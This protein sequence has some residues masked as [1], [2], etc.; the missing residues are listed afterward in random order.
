M[1]K[2]GRT[3]SCSK[4]RRTRKV[5]VHHNA[6][7]L[8]VRRGLFER[9]EPFAAYLWLESAETRDVAA[10]ARKAFVT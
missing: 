4:G 1:K 9:L 8:N 3:R 7:P 2:R 6:Y 5:R 10:R